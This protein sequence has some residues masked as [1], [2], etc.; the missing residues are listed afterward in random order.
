MKP[1]VMW[2]AGIFF[3][4]SLPLSVVRAGNVYFLDDR[5]EV[6][7]KLEL[8]ASS[9]HV[10]GSSGPDINL[11]EVLEADFDDHDFHLD[12]FSSRESPAHLPPTWEGQDISQAGVPGAFTY[13]SGTLTI[14]DSATM[15]QTGDP[16]VGT[17]DRCFFLGQ[18][19][20]DRAGQWTVRI[21]DRTDEVSRVGLMLRTSLDP[22]A[23]TF[24]FSCEGDH[25]FMSA[26]YKAG[27]VPS[28]DA[29]FVAPV[30]GWI[31]LTRYWRYFVC[32]ETSTDGTTWELT[33]QNGDMAQN[34]VSAFTSTEIGMF[35]TGNSP[36][37]PGKAVLDDITFTPAPAEPETVP[38]GVWLRSGSFLAGSFSGLD[39]KSGSFI[40]NGTIVAMT[41]DQVA[42]A[43]WEPTTLHQLAAVATQPGLIMKN[44]DFLTSDLQSLSSAGA[45]MSSVVLGNLDYFYT[46]LIRA[47]V[48]HPI[49]PR[50]SDYEIRL[51]DGSNIRSGNLEVRD[52]KLVI[53]EVSDITVTADPGEIAQ[54]R[55]GSVY[56][57]PLI[58]LPWKVSSP[59][60]SHSTA[61]QTKPVTP[62]VPDQVPPLPPVPPV[63]CWGG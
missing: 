14:N 29:R 55:A 37:V 26:R 38:P 35:V 23:P 27:T 42:A 30:P 58:E 1:V 15:A 7:G 57:Q 34:G 5:P 25:G 33:M 21:K 63:R 47:C 6:D 36:K 51:K 24:Q 45:Q 20:P 8:K 10:E 4:L 28:Y 11:T 19:W 60:E 43:M 46:N 62:V 3:G 48:L 2:L 59:A 32:V 44:G 9:I 13:A 56:V 61:G 40:R 53:H 16:I 41:A 50:L 52:G 39:A 18:A 12:C 22:A 54:F 49:Q 31:R 17:S